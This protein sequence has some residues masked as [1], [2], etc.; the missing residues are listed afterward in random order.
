MIVALGILG[1]LAVLVVGWAIW[2]RKQAMKGDR[3]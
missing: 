1:A 3:G 2:A